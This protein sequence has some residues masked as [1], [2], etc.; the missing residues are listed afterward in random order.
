MTKELPGQV[1]VQVTGHLSP[2]AK[3]TST[4]LVKLK[5]LHPLFSGTITTNRTD[6]DQ[7]IPQLNER[8][9]KKTEK[10]T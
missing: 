5:E 3:P 6:I 4:D 10:C 7:T 8:T 9:S 2:G 1:E